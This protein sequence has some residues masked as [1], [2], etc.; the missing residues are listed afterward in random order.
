KQSY[1]IQK[2]L[3]RS[4][5]PLS[6]VL[7]V[8]GGLSAALVHGLRVNRDLQEQLTY[9]YVLRAQ[10]SASRGDLPAALLCYGELNRLLPSALARLNALAC[11]A[12]FDTSPVVLDNAVGVNTVAYSP[13]GGL[14]AAGNRDGSV[15]LYNLR[16]EA[17]GE[18]LACGSAV[19]A[20]LFS[21]DG[22]RLLTGSL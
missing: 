6:A 19:Q 15:R 2:F 20:L 7:L 14:L 4:R 22:K 1:R 12:E 17:Q 3:R 9:S 21:P 10:Q 5:G 16:G 11:L 18:A 13:S 8:L